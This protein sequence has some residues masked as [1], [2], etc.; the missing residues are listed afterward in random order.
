LRVRLGTAAAAYAASPENSFA[1]GLQALLDGLEAQL[2]ACRTPATPP[3][4]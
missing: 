1:F 3:R 2:R 4:P